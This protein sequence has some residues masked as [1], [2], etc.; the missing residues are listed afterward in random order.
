MAN[1]FSGTITGKNTGHTNQANLLYA[2][3][4]RSTSS[5]IEVINSGTASLSGNAFGSYDAD[6]YLIGGSTSSVSTAIYTV[7]TFDITSSFTI[8][9]GFKYLGSGAGGAIRAGITHASNPA[10]K[11]EITPDYANR[12]GRPDFSDGGAQ[13]LPGYTTFGADHVGIAAKSTPGAQSS[14]YVEGSSSPPSGTY[15]SIGTDTDTFSTVASDLTLLFFQ[16]VSS[17]GWQYVFVYNDDLSDANIESIIE[18]PGS[19]LSFG[20]ASEALSGSA[21]TGGHGTASP[22]FSIGL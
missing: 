6:G 14:G 19:V 11:L 13:F 10:I 8:I 17:W 2:L 9:A 1:P 18:D 16:G 3:I 21:A 12:R 22:A 4:P 5:V 15:T 20:G 7:P